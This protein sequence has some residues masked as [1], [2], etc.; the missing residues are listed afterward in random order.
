M[1]LHYVDP[2]SKHGRRYKALESFGASLGSAA[3]CSAA[4]GR[5]AGGR[6]PVGAGVG[7]NR[8]WL[9]LRHWRYRL[10]VR[11]TRCPGSGLDLTGG[12]AVTPER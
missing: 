9:R 2:H 5:A 8:E 11:H 4:V 1:P 10:Q 12:Q 3:A 7:C 6:R